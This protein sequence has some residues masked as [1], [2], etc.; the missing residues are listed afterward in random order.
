VTASAALK[1]VGPFRLGVIMSHP[2]QYHSPWFRELASL[3][4]LELEVLYCFQPD[5]AQQGK[6]FGVPFTWDV[7]LLDGYRSR[8]LTNVSRRPGFHFS[9]CDTPEISGIIAA[10]HYDAF[11]VSGWHV[12]SYWQAMRACWRRKLPMLVRG[13]SHLLD[14]RSIHVRIAKR[15]VLGRWIPRFAAYLT[16]GVLNE[17]FY[18]Y[19]GAD[20]SRFFPVRHFVDNEAFARGAMEARGSLSAHRAR[21]KIPEDALVAL[22][23]GKF[24]DVKRPMDVI[25]AVEKRARAGDHIHLMMV[26]EGPLRAGCERYATQNGVPVSFTGFLNQREM[27][28][29]YACAHVLVLS[30]TSETWGLVVNEAMACGLPAIVTNKVGCG[31]DLVKEEDTGSIYPVGDIDALA[32]ELASYAADRDMTRRRGMHAKDRSAGYNRTEAAS[33]TL[34][35]VRSVARGNG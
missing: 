26:G 34:L 1:R 23:A 15:M 35:A 21:W 28:A 5:A 25:R 32:S 33:G 24:I 18:E 22:F 30:S 16:V 31:P 17:Q 20:R 19:Y 6:G 2:T 11:L 13:D 8:F 7:S 29:A 9:G 3:P 27:P 10:A 4:D 12:K 14:R